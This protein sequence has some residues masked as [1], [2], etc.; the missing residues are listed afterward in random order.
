MAVDKSHAEKVAECQ[1]AILKMLNS[2]N[3]IEKIKTLIR[4]TI[5]D[6]NWTQTVRQICSKK[7]DEE[8]F[9]GLT[10][11]IL[12]NI[13]A[14]EAYKALPQSLHVSIEKYITDVLT[15]KQ[16]QERPPQ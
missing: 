15:K 8:N 1:K 11:E 10:P 7:I 16:V 2:E 12:T 14:D 3:E 9:D 5:S 6:S 13:I 4:N